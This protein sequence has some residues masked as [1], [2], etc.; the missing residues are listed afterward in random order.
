MKLG[1]TSYAFRH[2]LQDPK[3]APSLRSIV[4]L[5][6]AYGLDMLQVCEN[7]HPTKLPIEDWRDIVQ[8]AGEA[9]VEI[10]L[11]CKTLKIEV[12]EVHLERV[13]DTLSK[14]LRIVLE[15]EGEPPPRRSLIEAF[16]HQAVPMLQKSSLRLAIENHFAIPAQV[17]AEIVRP[18]PS[19]SVGFCVDTA[20]SLRTFE[21]SEYVL[22]LLGPRAFCYHIKDYKVT[23]HSVGF[24]VGGAPLGTGDLALDKFL[25]AV[26]ALDPLPVLFLENWVPSSGSRE[27]DVEADAHWLHESVLNLRGR[28]SRRG[29]IPL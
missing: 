7:A 9:G 26:F 16:L 5:T 18:Y 2:L 25:D 27:T 10:H 4:E 12:L 6:R 28:L 21:S 19:S 1:V 3:D 11:G 15:E 29:R 22:Q 24:S 8:G 20:N 13:T 17:L 14:T 23:G